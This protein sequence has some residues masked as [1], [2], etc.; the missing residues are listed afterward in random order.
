MKNLIVLMM[1]MATLMFQ[2]N[3]DGGL[4][5]GNQLTLD[6]I[7]NGLKFPDNS[8]QGTA[9]PSVY[10]ANGQ[11]IGL[12]FP[13]ASY[14]TLIAYIPSR[15]KYVE[16]SI[17]S[18]EI[19]GHALYYAS[20]NCSGQPFIG[21]GFALQIIKVGNQ[22]YTYSHGSPVYGFQYQSIS[23]GACVQTTSTTDLVPATA[24]TLPFTV[25]ILL[26]MSLN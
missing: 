5:I 16:I 19:Y 13:Q 9:S 12:A 3:A 11:F 4:I 8:F 6:G 14:N 22:F 17:S 24:V 20:N 15:G 26:P 10:D 23:N 18:G 2:K 1:I 21:A 25:P 7:E